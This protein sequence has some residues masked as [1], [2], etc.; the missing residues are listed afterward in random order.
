MVTIHDR[1][2]YFFGNPMSRLWTGQSLN[3]VGFCLNISL[4]IDLVTIATTIDTINK[5]IS[6]PYKAKSYF[7][8]MI[9]FPSSFFVNNLELMGGETG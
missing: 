4:A 7:D 6:T 8:E 1:L 2:G 5:Q 9:L 3:C